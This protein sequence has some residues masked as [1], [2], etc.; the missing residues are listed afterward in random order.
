MQT[1]ARELVGGLDLLPS[2]GRIVL[3]IEGDSDWNLFVN[4]LSEEL[5]GLFRE[6]DNSASLDELLWNISTHLQGNS[7]LYFAARYER[8][9]RELK[10]LIRAAAAML[11]RLDAK[12]L[13][14]AARLTV[15]EDS[16]TRTGDV[17]ARIELL[18]QARLFGPADVEI[19]IEM[20][21]GIA[22]QLAKE[23]AL[24]RAAQLKSGTTG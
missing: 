3:A 22:P 1:T 19:L 6:Q 15:T 18:G 24:D 16:D 4:L 13:I 12:Q 21:A 14:H 10:S 17:I 23:G 20:M 9:L 7:S 8:A 2:A 11:N 5:L